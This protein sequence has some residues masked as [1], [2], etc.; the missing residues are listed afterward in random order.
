MV[1]AAKV[2]VE[3]ATLRFDKPYTYLVPQNLQAKLKAGCRV[4]VPFGAGNRPRFG[5]VMEIS[6]I[7]S[8]DRLKEVASI[9]DEEPLL[10]EEMLYLV[11]Y[12]YIHIL[13]DAL[14]GVPV[15]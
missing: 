4:V 14:S 2:V 3:N 13:I 5:L 7:T 9:V 8:S 6:D 10:S 11:N 1:K 12:L 15:R